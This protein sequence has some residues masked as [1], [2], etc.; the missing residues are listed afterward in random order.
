MPTKSS[1]S[2]IRRF[3]GRRGKQRLIDA[4]RYQVLVAGDLSLARALADHTILGRALQAML[5]RAGVALENWAAR[6]GVLS[7]RTVLTFRATGPASCLGPW[8]VTTSGAMVP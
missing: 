8:M 7:T 4:L 3:V 5:D 6:G 2:V 1:A